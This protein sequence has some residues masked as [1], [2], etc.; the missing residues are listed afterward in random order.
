MAEDL[1]ERTEEPTP[2]RRSEARREGNV[3]RSQELSGALML[4]AATVVVAGALLPVLGSFKAMMEAAL[5][6][7]AITTAEALRAARAA[8]AA[9]VRVTLPVM[10]ALAGFAF[11]VQ[12][13]QVGWVFAP[14]VLAPKLGNI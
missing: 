11:L 1:G 4:L 10:L 12:F 6:S 2:R 7:G 9:G 13:V 3:A 14:G 8:A 5:S